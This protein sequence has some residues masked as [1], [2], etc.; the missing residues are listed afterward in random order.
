MKLQIPMF[1][2]PLKI[3]FVDDDIELLK[4]YYHLDLP[5]KMEI[6]SDPHIALE[7]LI[8]QANKTVKIFNDITNASDIN[9]LTTNDEAIIRFTFKNIS[10]LVHN[11]DKYNNYGMV[12]VDYKMHGMNGI[13]LCNKISSEFDILKIL[14]TGEYSPTG[15][16]AAFNENIIDSFLQ[17][18]TETTITALLNS[19]NA[20]QLKYFRNITQNF[21]NLTENK[22]DFL[23]DVDFINLVNN[24]IHEHNITEYYLLSNTG[25][26]LMKNKLNNFIL[27]VY[28]DTD[29]DIFCEM[30]EH[31][32]PALIEEVKLRKLIP[33][34]KLP[35]QTNFALTDY[36]YPC[37]QSGPYYYNLYKPDKDNCLF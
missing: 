33:N 10:K 3:L 16:V 34:F 17:K 22:C 13:E 12:V 19:I 7:K 20:L 11:Q 28:T 31:L 37:E 36:F 30:Y 24:F 18:G 14:L 1:Y 5:N 8:N 35:E 25:C 27:N 32:N 26:Y 2:Y 9:S 15:A 23:Y 4:S 29:L 6:E 21:L